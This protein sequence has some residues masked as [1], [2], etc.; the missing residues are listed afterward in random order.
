MVRILRDVDLEGFV[1][2]PEIVARMEEGYRADAA[3]EVVL[4]PRVRNEAAGVTLAWL[5]AAL[6]SRDLLGYRTYL[7]GRE[8]EDR[9]EQAVTLY[10]HSD[11]SLRAIFVG[12]L[13]GNL[14]TGAT[15]AAA[16]HLLAPDAREIGL[17]GTGTQARNA[18][19]CVV[20]TFHPSRLVVWSPDAGHREKFRV[21]AHRTLRA[22]VEIASS[23]EGVASRCD[24]V[25]LATSADSP[26]LSADSLGGPRLLLSISAYRRPELD[27]RILDSVGTIW[28]DSVLQA[29]APGTLLA[30]PE[31]RSKVR[32]LAEGLTDGAARDRTVHRL[33]INTGA[34]WEEVLAADALLRRAETL[35]LGTPLDLPSAPPDA[36]VP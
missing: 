5:G 29:S 8:G 2:V 26:I 27:P 17:I 23:A 10:R 13:V 15:L 28:T 4:L 18:A 6:P 33:V 22:E 20:A 32:P 16:L 3:G 21:W 30:S 35:G 19:A 11:M 31:R 1:D 9:G 25:L 14:R 12:R 36:A 34:G 24:S 7:H